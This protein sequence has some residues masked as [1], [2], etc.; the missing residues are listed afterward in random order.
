MRT[1]LAALMLLTFPLVAQASLTTPYQANYFLASLDGAVYF[2]LVVPQTLQL[3]ALDLNLYSPLG[4]PGS[5]DV[6]LRPG[7]WVDHS[8]QR[9]DWAL[10]AHGA[11]TSAGPQLPTPCAL[12]APIGLPPGTYGVALHHRGVMPSYHFAF[13]LRTYANADLRLIGGGSSML[14]FGG[15]QF[16]SRV[17]SGALHYSLGGGPFSLATVQAHGVGCHQSASSF[18]EHFMPGTLDLAGTRLRLT[19][20]GNGGYDVQR[21]PS[22]SIVLPA[23]AHNL[24]LVRGSAAFVQLA[25]ELTFPGGSSSSLLVL[26]DG[27]VHLTSEGLLGT[28][29]SSPS[30]ATLLAGR[31]TLAANWQD[32]APSGADN[33]YTSVDPITGALTI[34]WWQLP[35]FA[36]PN[37]VRNTFALTVH[38]NGVLDLRLS[39]AANPTDACVVGWSPGNAARDGGAIDLSQSVNFATGTDDDGLGLVAEG[40]PVLGTTTRLQVTGTTANSFCVLMLGWQL[41]A[42]SIELGIVGAAGCELLV[43]PT[44][45]ATTSIANNALPLAVPA[46]PFLLGVTLHAQAA[47]F[48]SALRTSNALTL[49]IGS[50]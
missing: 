8:T 19:P 22:G 49:V 5:I 38:T 41:L 29:T 20:N 40:R 13:G 23:N 10:A 16:F 11:V 21:S 28:S 2:D 25:T 1:S 27:R 43:D 6:Y 9:G 46:A 14:A 50:V 34:T 24:D 45:M 26:P 42:P 37:N 4:T 44:T 12:S 18:Y 48:A 31:A 36:G 3:D 33:V 47:D 17:F 35:L 30:V 39:A 32:Y 15:Q 7:T